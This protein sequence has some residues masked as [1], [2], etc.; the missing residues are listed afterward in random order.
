MPESAWLDRPP[1]GLTGRVRGRLEATAREVAGEWGVALGA[2]IE[3][4]RY[5]FVAYAGPDAIL[6]VTPVEDDEADHEADALALWAGDG[7]VRLLRHDRARR[8]MLV[9][10]AVPG[11]EAAAVGEEEA[12]AAALS[13]ARRI[14]RPLPHGHPFRSLRGH[15]PRWIENAG[16]HELLR[17]ARETFEKMDVRDGTLVHGDLH[18]HN[19]LRHGDRWVVIDAKAMAG[20]PE[21]DVPTFFWNPIGSVPT[22]ARIERWT[23]AFA[24]IGLD[25]ARI[26]EWAIVR[27]AYLGL[28]LSAGETEDDSPQ[29]RTARLV[30]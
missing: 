13:V 12:L 21:F 20:E 6:K 10:R 2:T 16:E 5:S 14:W 7:A 15:V 19:V 11:T 27:G 29:L 22:R 30:L 1:W 18:H 4:G 17:I 3:T 26:R 23:A 28:P 25:P 9:E 24:A 8:A